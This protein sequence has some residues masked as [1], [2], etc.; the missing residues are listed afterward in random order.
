MQCVIF[1]YSLK[2][3]SEM[4]GSSLK[5]AIFNFLLFFKKVPSVVFSPSLNMQVVLFRRSLNEQS[6]NFGSSLKGAVCN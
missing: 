6:V 3:Q 5:G 1:C 4:F 2:V